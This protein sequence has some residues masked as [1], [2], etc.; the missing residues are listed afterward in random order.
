M[1]DAHYIAGI[2]RNGA[3]AYDDCPW[4]T[5]ALGHLGEVLLIIGLDLLLPR[6]QVVWIA[7]AGSWCWMTFL[8]A[9]FLLGCL[10]KPTE[11]S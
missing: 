6:Y 8:A 3:A 10:E 4:I 9:V 2:L 7:F 1:R 5:V 11:V